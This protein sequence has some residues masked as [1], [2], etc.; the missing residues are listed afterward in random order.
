M[1]SHIGVSAH[2]LALPS[3]LIIAGLVFTAVYND[4]VFFVANSERYVGRP[5]LACEI[6]S[7]A[8]GTAFLV[9]VAPR[10]YLWNT[11]STRRLGLRRAFLFV[12]A[13]LIAACTY[14]GFRPADPLSM[15]ETGPN[16]AVVVC[17]VISVI[18]LAAILISLLGVGIA[19]PTL[20][21]ITIALYA[22][23]ARG[24]FVGF[25][26]FTW[27]F[28]PPDSASSVAEFYSAPPLLGMTILVSLALVTISTTAMVPPLRKHTL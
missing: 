28:L 24:L 15:S 8:I 2:R 4:T 20:V 18:A 6:G 3:V 21:A 16:N 23:Q 26:P 19:V 27:T 10:F 25:L 1:S 7:S 9:A 13:T 11:L 17:N 14:I 22:A 12:V 5:V